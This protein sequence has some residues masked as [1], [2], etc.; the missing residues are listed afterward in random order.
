VLPDSHVLLK[1][2]H[3]T[4]TP[5]LAWTRTQAKSRIVT[6]QMGHDAHAFNDANYRRLLTQAIAWTAGR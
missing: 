4:S 6:I 1:T 2:D 5:A 3:P